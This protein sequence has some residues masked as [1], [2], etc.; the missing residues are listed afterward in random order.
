MVEVFDVKT[1]EFWQTSN[2]RFFAQESP[3]FVKFFTTA[4]EGG[5]YDEKGLKFSPKMMS[6][7]AFI[8]A[9]SKRLADNSAKYPELMAF[10]LP[11]GWAKNMAQKLYGDKRKHTNIYP[12]VKKLQD[13]GVL[14]YYRGEA[15]EVPFFAVN[16]YVAS[17]L[18]DK[19]T[20]RARGAWIKLLADLEANPSEPLDPEEKNS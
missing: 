19:S 17:V 5:T 20:Q 6:A 1:G 12:L 2:T 4:W 8:L 14:V 15:G 11:M 3:R 13:E 16:P 18:D 9:R 10:Y 7:L